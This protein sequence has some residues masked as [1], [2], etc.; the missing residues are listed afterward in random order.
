MDPRTLRVL[1]YD[2]I[3]QRLREQ[4][5]SSLGKELAERLEPATDEATVRRLMAE[6]TQALTV[7]DHGGKAPLGGVHDVRGQVQNAARG[8][9]L[10]GRDLLEV[11]DTLYA[12]RRMRTYLVKSEVGAVLVV[13]HAREL[14]VFPELEGLIEGSIDSR[15]DVE[16][17]ASDQ[18]ARVRARVRCEPVDS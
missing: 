2:A 7:L 3:R 6:T 5:S 14:S 4:A 9:T 13:A 1:E 12:S 8:G 11:A 18:L 17:R 16:D 10:S 15:G